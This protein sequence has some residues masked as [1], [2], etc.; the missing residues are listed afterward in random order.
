[1]DDTRQAPRPPFEQDASAEPPAS[2]AVRRFLTSH[3]VREHN[4][5]SEIARIIAVD[6]SQS[7]RRL[8]GDVAWSHDD[9]RA[10]ARYFGAKEEQLIA[11]LEPGTTPMASEPVPAAVRVPRL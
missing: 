4:H 10:I 11:Q 5:A 9:L 8:K 3:G 7:Y 2:V 1:M 6:R